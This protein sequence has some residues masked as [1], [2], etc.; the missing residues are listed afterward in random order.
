MKKKTIFDDYLWE[1][2]INWDGYEVT[3]KPTG[4]TIAV[5]IQYA[6]PTR[7]FRIDSFIGNKFEI[8]AEIK[9]LA[10]EKEK[11]R[12]P[13]YKYD[14]ITEDDDIEGFESPVLYNKGSKVIDDNGKMVT[15]YK[16]RNNGEPVL[17]YA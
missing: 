12:I 7:K 16:V 1:A 15:I 3:Y 13:V 17:V 11:G 4:F 9:R 2:A 6:E 10:M 5:Y 8:M 14:V